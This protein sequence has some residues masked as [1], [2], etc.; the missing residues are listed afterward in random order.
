MDKV[1][2]G[3]CG[4]SKDTS[5]F[6]SRGPNRPD[7]LDYRCKS[8]HNAARNERGHKG[9]RKVLQ[10]YNLSFDTYSGM[11]KAQD[12]KCKICLREFIGTPHVDHD[13]RCCPTGG[14]C[15]KCVRGLLCMSCNN[16]LGSFGDNIGVLQ[17]AVAYLS[18][19]V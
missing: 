17:N 9:R 7:K 3:A 13:H 12:N 10:R 5:E 11:L 4:Q 8:C 18:V 16:G 1:C 19:T 2:G 15:G 6:Y 14:S